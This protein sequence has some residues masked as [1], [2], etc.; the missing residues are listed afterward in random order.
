MHSQSEP[1]RSAAAGRRRHDARTTIRR[2]RRSTT[3]CAG[4]ARCSIGDETAEVGPGDAIAIPPGATHQ[5]ANTGDETLVFLCCCAP[6]Y[7]H[8]DTVLVEDLTRAV[9]YWLVQ[10]VPLSFL[11]S[12]ARWIPRMSAAA[13]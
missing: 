2:P 6:G 5:I 10:A 12:V 1:G 3:S 9:A 11:R 8:A 13:E 4:R 7:E